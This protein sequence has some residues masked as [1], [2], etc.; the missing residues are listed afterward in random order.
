MRINLS[1]Q[2]HLLL[3]FAGI[4]CIAAYIWFM[5]QEYRLSAILGIAALAV[6]YV[7]FWTRSDAQ[8]R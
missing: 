5:L 6:L 3:I 7:Y 8:N 1:L 2:K 4:I